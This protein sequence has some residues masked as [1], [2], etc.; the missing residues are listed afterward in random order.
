MDGKCYVTAHTIC[1]DEELKSTTKF[2]IA[3]VASA[4]ILAVVIGYLTREA[5]IPIAGTTD[6]EAQ[7]PSATSTPEQWSLP[8][9]GTIC[10]SKK[11]CE[12]SLWGSCTDII[13]MAKDTQVTIRTPEQILQNFGRNRFFLGLD[14]DS[15]TKDNNRLF[16][17]IP[18]II[19]AGFLGIQKSNITNVKAKL[20]EIVK[21]DLLR[22]KVFFA[23]FQMSKDLTAADIKVMTKGLTFIIIET[24]R[25]SA[26]TS[27]VLPP[28]LFIQ[29]S[30]GGEATFED[31]STLLKNLRNF[32]PKLLMSATV[33]VFQYKVASP[34]RE[35]N[36]YSEAVLLAK[37]DVD[38][39]EE[40]ECNS[41]I[42]DQNSAVLV[43]AAKTTAY[44]Y[45]NAF[46]LKAKM[47]MARSKIGKD[48]DISWA[49]Y[50]TRCQDDLRQERSC[51]ERKPDPKRTMESKKWEARPRLY[52][53]IGPCPASRDKHLTEPCTDII[54]YDNAWDGSTS[55]TNS[56]YME[57]KAPTKS[58]RYYLGIAGS[59]LTV[60][61]AV[62]KGI[63]R[64]AA[65]G[66]AGIAV[67]DYEVEPEAEYLIAETLFKD[68]TETG[69][70]K[71]L[72]L[73]AKNPVVEMATSNKI[74]LDT[75]Y[76]I[77]QSHSIDVYPFCTFHPTA[78]YMEESS[79]SSEPTRLISAARLAE[80]FSN[81][82]L[83]ITLEVNE[84]TFSAVQAAVPEWGSE[85]VNCISRPMV[86]KD[87]PTPP[88]KA[89]KNENAAVISGTTIAVYENVESV[90][91]KRVIWER[92]WAVFGIPCA[93]I[94][95]CP[96]K[97]VIHN[98]G[99]NGRI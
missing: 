85:C 71:V 35:T 47:D 54:Y 98:M 11:L 2:V 65:R 75:V 5:D 89:H 96:L 83:S 17:I 95:S 87:C 43:N 18:M 46:S 70:D 56:V 39:P 22:T 8:P 33:S 93:D 7:G 37:E 3:V 59:K 92:N 61:D 81:A 58:Q 88:S 53:V 23:G 80:E 9:Y 63:I 94:P 74:I 4:I 36:L 49:L 16:N 51:V 72:V 31:V 84:Y 30:H 15:T 13:V 12:Y 45:E 66:F 26:D 50:S 19:G 62:V 32:V 76:P 38:F 44:L 64:R 68:I 14:Q 97:D 48:A 24:H 21:Y 86:A 57:A 25:E 41:T 55:P 69:M 6:S 1:R 73:P 77:F 78:A 42:E 90:T 40:N 67:L 27:K 82:A 60:A 91:A 29:G 28:S 34:L 52:C 99:S 20:E 10:I 79:N